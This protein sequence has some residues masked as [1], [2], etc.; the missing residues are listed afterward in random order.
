[1][2][3]AATLTFA[4]GIL[5][6]VLA[7][8]GRASLHHPTDQR[9]TIPVEENGKPEALPFDAF[10]LRRVVVRNMGISEWKGGPEP[11]ERL[12]LA[13]R[14]K[15]EQEKP[16]TKRTVEESVALA[17]DLLH[18]GK[19]DEAEGILRQQQRGFLPNITLAHIAIT[20]GDWLQADD[21]LEIANGSPQPKESPPL[22][23]QKLKWQ[24]ELNR[25]ALNK[26][27]RL[28]LAE[29]GAKKPQP[30]NELPDQLWP[31]NFVNDKGEYEPGK[32]AAAEKAKLPGG[33]FDEAIATVQQLVLW[34]PFDVRL[35]WLLGELYAAK[36]EAKSAEDIMSECVNTGR[37]SN[38]KVLMQHREV[39]MKAVKD[40]EKAEQLDDATP[41]PAVPFSFSTVWIYLGVVG[42]VALFALGRALWKLKKGTSAS[43]SKP[44]G[45]S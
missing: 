39:V 8:N 45:G 43:A 23:K 18:Y 3:R 22:S 5:V 30:E 29:T 14:I 9:A 16:A 4:V 20:K 1:V 38:R 11:A 19:F 42:A 25:G 24:L 35:Y 21:F 2:T 15:K 33:D 10:K 37:Y 7:S 44:A 32:L 6:I 40:Q 12:E 41:A 28:R 13:E 26:L 17:I 31:V 36:G 34:F 27:V